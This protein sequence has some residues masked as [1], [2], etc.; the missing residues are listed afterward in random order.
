MTNNNIF[1][2]GF[3]GSGKSTLGKK[4]ANKLNQPFFDLDVVI[5]TKENKTITQLFEEKGEEYFR[6]LEHQTLKELIS[7]NSQ[8][9]LSL[10]GGTPCFKNNMQLINANGKSVYLKYNVGILHSRLVNAKTKR[11]L[12]Q[13]KSD[14][15]LKQFINEKLTEREIFYKQAQFIIEG[16]NLKVEDLIKLIQ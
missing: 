16:G 7:E 10:G 9:V 2:L 3:M 1:L 15:E 6:A 4:L 12:L 14:E 13:G 11:P 8:F 5:E